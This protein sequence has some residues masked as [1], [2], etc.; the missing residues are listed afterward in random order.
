MANSLS[1]VPDGDKGLVI[2]TPIV[3][4]LI[5]KAGREMSEAQWADLEGVQPS[6]ADMRTAERM[7]KGARRSRR[8]ATVA[9]RT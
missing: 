4:E 3:D 6:I 5:L 7:L 1:G 2:E 9:R 8:A